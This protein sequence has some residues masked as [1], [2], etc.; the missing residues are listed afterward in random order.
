MKTTLLQIEGSIARR[1]WI[2]QGRSAVHI[3]RKKKIYLPKGEGKGRHLDVALAQMSCLLR[4]WV[5]R[6]LVMQD[7]KACHLRHGNW[8]AGQRYPLFK[9]KSKRLFAP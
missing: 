9:V 1:E 6:E 3:L 4:L 8:L 2:G 7:L 5:D